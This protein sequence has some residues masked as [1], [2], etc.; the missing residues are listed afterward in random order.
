MCLY[1]RRLKKV[2]FKILKDYPRKERNGLM[3]ERD[4]SSNSIVETVV[5]SENFRNCPSD[6]N[7][8]KSYT[9]NGSIHKVK[10]SSINNLG[11]D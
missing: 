10:R 8:S 3:K 6:V 5:K 1:E 2:N 11:D 4:K 9:Q 7:N